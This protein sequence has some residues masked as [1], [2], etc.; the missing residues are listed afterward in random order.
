MHKQSLNRI[1]VVIAGVLFVIA[2]LAVFGKAQNKGKEEAE[3]PIHSV[4]TEAEKKAR[5]ELET[6]FRAIQEEF[7]ASIRAITIT[8]GDDKLLLA[9]YK[10]KLTSIKADSIKTE[11][12]TWLKTVLEAHKCPT[13]G[14]DGDNLVKP[15]L[16]AKPGK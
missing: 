6:K 4:L 15:K 13:C 10:L 7:G 11:F 5:N 2:A 14:L 9:A 16:E 3:S 12:T 1:L 8:E